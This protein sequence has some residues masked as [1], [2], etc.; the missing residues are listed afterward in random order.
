MKIM[1]KQTFK[2]LS[3]HVTVNEPI[4]KV[5]KNFTHPE[6][7][8]HWYN[9]SEDWHAPRATNDLRA[10]GKFLTRMEAKDGSFG[11]DFEGVYSEVIDYKLIV[12]GLAD[13]RQVQVKFLELNRKTTEVLEVFDAETVNPLEM[14]QTG[15]QNILNN[16]KR[17][18][19]T[20]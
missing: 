6:D 10:G 18:C 12:Y 19:E 9:A 5:W 7:I 20:Y 1:E 17:Y 14:Q 2:T 16:F 8:V 13:G 11:F 15:W 4:E 3:V